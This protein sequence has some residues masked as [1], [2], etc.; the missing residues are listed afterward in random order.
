MCTSY[1]MHFLL[2]FL[3]LRGCFQRDTLRM[4]KLMH[5]RTSSRKIHLT[6]W[7]LVSIRENLIYLETISLAIS[8]RLNFTVLPGFNQREEK[9]TTS[10]N[11]VREKLWSSQQGCL[12]KKIPHCWSKSY[13]LMPCCILMKTWSH[14]P[15][16]PVQLMDGEYGSIRRHTFF[17]A[18]F[19]FW[20]LYWVLYLNHL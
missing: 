5:Q 13:C 14:A 7:Q 20:L 4:G 12:C 1:C 19:Y 18:L 2:V 16:F 17:S 6:W 3:W 8:F 11:L 9:K 15:D 10:L